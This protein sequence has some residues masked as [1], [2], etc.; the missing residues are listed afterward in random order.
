MM[1]N[2]QCNAR[3]VSLVLVLGNAPVGNEDGYEKLEVTKNF[4]FL[5]NS[6]G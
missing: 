6:G 1:V 3:R 4:R 5:G 2:S